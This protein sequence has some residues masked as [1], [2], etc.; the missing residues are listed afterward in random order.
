MYPKLQASKQ[1]IRQKSQ[2]IA[3][4]YC[5]LS[6]LNYSTPK[7]VL[8]S[9]MWECLSWLNEREKKKPRHPLLPPPPHT[10]TQR[11]YIAVPCQL[12]NLSWSRSRKCVWKSFPKTN[13]YL[14]HCDSLVGVS[15]SFSLVIHQFQQAA[16]WHLRRCGFFISAKRATEAIISVSMNWDFLQSRV[17]LLHSEC[18]CH[19]IVFT[20]TASVRKRFLL[21]F[22]HHPLLFSLIRNVNQNPFTSIICEE[23][24]IE[25]RYFHHVTQF[26]CWSHINE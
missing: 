2:Q 11:S 17:T 12:G 1:S 3:H 24:I 16:L 7:V 6:E 4:R 9:F 26:H 25:S 13:Q 22:F 19:Y 15:V 10:H 5:G 23:K 18:S 14:S 8:K 20:W 21:F